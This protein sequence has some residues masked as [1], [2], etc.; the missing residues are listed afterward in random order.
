MSEDLP[1]ELAARYELEVELGRGGMGRVLRCRDRELGRVVALKL[2][3]GCIG[4]EHWARYTREAEALARIRHPHVVEVY[5][6]GVTELGPYLVMEYLEGCLLDELEPTVDPLPPLLQL[7]EA[8]Q[9]LHDS[10]LLHRDVKPGNVLVVPHRGVVLLDF[11]LVYDPRQTFLT[12]EGV[13]VGTP[14]FLAPEVLRGRPW[15]PAS[16]WFAWGVTAFEVHEQ[17]LPF[18]WEVLLASIQGQ[19]SP[20]R[21]QRLAEE[22]PRA[23]AIRAC[24]AED[25][26]QRPADAEALRKL[27]RGDR[28][29]PPPPQAA[30]RPVDSQALTDGA[31]RRRA[32]P[33]AALPLLLAAALGLGAVASWWAPSVTP[34]RP[35]DASLRGELVVVPGL[36]TLE[37]D[38]EEVDVDRYGRAVATGVVP[39]PLAWARQRQEGARPV[40]FVTPDQAE[41][42]C[43]AAGGR[44]PTAREWRRAAGGEARPYPWGAAR[45][46]P[47]RAGFAA[48]PRDA[49]VPWH[50]ALRP[51]RDYAAGATPEGILGLVGGVGEWARE[52]L[53]SHD[54]RDVA[55]GGSW[56]SAAEALRLDAVP[57]LPP[58]VDGA[59]GFR[60]A[61]DPPGIRSQP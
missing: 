49:L 53:G 54:V 26:A 46:D 14:A 41:A 3:L 57:V 36:P 11:G 23:R 60:C 50:A 30:A 33:S 16:D 17:H 48:A 28:G 51:T 12:A 31:L 43:Q 1:P 52:H 15:S 34:P 39:E 25:P 2:V 8:L 22:S 24:L 40:V 5:D 42:F 59:T 35:G 27:H 58:V 32:G 7:A 21:F 61:Y 56:R 6:F 13:V 45:P 55:L 38:R 37:L 47:A 18:T 9:V 20:P 44:L 4:R 10:G 19:L 29:P